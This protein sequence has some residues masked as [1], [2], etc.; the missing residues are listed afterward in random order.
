MSMTREVFA[1]WMEQYGR[2]WEKRDAEAAAALYAE[3]GT[4][5]VTPF[6]KPMRGRAAILE[7]W[8]HVVQTQENIHFGYEILALAQEHGIARWWATLVIIPQQL[9]T[10]LDGI[11]VIA[12]DEEGR[13]VQLRE[14]WHKHQSD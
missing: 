2:A 5:Q 12:L 1:A 7:Y 8:T 10:Q 14:W 4:Y 11:F 13:C 3:D 6:V 9:K